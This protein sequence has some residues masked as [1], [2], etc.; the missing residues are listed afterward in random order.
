M[1]RDR[2]GTGV[3][4]VGIGGSYHICLTSVRL[5]QYVRDTGAGVNMN[6]HD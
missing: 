2:A 5:N 3:G 1:E 6:G 4:D